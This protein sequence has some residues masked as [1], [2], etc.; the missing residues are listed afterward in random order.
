MEL[1]N[2]SWRNGQH[3]THATNNVTLGIIYLNI[4]FC[5]CLLSGKFLILFNL[6]IGIWSGIWI[7]WFLVSS[8]IIWHQSPSS[9]I[10]WHHWNHI[11]WQNLASSGIIWHLLALPGITWHHQASSSI[12]WHCP[13]WCSIIWQLHIASTGIIRHNVASSGNF[14]LHQLVSPSNIYFPSPDTILLLKVHSW[15]VATV[16]AG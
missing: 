3:N 13:T 7:I 8:G 11:M 9:I 10:C 1:D 15:P 16:I 2:N 14:I 4:W 6:V 12:I 5:I